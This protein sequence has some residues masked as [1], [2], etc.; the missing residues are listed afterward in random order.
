VSPTE[1]KEGIMNVQEKQPKIEKKSVGRQDINCHGSFCGFRPG[2]GD[3]SNEECAQT[4]SPQEG[5]ESS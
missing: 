4:Q 1:E 3:E 2:S 5:C